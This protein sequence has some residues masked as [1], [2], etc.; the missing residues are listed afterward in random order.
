MKWTPQSFL[1]G[2]LG[3]T[4]SGETHLYNEGTVVV[5]LEIEVNA[6]SAWLVRPAAMKEV[7]LISPGRRRLL[8]VANR[9]TA[10]RVDHFVD[11]R[12][13]ADLPSKLNRPSSR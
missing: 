7:P 9:I 12:W 13:L 5:M 8:T 4:S 1:A 2:D 11:V 10:R 3:G 6:S